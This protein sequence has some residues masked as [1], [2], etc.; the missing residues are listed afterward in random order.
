MSKKMKK[1]AAGLG[2][3]ALILLLLLFVNSWTGNPVSEAL[4][5]NSA[6]KYIDANYRGLNL[7]IQDCSYSFKEGAYRVF[8]QSQNSRDTAFAVY[9]NSFGT[10][11]YDN[12]ENEVANHFTTWRRL[13]EELRTA[14]RDRMATLDYDFEYCAFSLVT[15]KKDNLDLLLLPL[16]MELELHNP[17]LPLLADVVV[18]HSEVS[19]ETIAEVAKALEQELSQQGIPI[20]QYSIRIIPEENKTEEEGGASSWVNDLAV[21]NFPAEQMNAENLP[22]VM[23]AFQIAQNAQ[24]EKENPK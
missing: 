13:D 5:K 16:D 15:N 19:Y 11:L 23:E 21:S 8:V 17:P 14:G 18:F 6:Q 20:S 12:Y 3:I 7:E 4:A 22:Q 9:G 2:G 10:I 1:W 24:Y